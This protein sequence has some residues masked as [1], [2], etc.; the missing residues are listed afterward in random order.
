V[1]LVFKLSL[2]ILQK[3][4]LTFPSMLPVVFLIHKLDTSHG[5]Y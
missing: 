1:Y 2:R 4:M 5:D 3:Y